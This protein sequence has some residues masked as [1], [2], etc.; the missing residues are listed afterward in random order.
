MNYSPEFGY[1]CIWKL[2]DPRDMYICLE[3]WTSVPTEGVEDECFDGRAHMFSLAP[4]NTK[5]F[6]CDISFKF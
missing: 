4:D 6:W 3:P 5:S 2:P 1:F